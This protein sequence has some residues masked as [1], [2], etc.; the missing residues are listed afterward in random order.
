MEKGKEHQVNDSWCRFAPSRVQPALAIFKINHVCLRQS[1][2]VIRTLI[3]VQV[4]PHQIPFVST[5]RLNDGK[6]IL[7][8]VLQM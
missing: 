1:R 8:H 4:R 2:Y 5:S 7:E 6:A 3:M